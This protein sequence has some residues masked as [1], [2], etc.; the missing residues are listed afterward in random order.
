MTRDKC[1]SNPLNKVKFFKESPPK[2]RILSHE[3]EKTLL[4]SS[5][6]HIRPILITALNTGMRYRELLNLKWDDVDLDS[7]Y[8]HVKTSKTGKDRK[9]PINQTLRNPFRPT[10]TKVC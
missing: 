4:D 8:I 6:N 3:E 5:P 10:F 7:N 1:K 9:I 2:E